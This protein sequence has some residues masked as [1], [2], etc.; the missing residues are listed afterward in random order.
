MYDVVTFVISSPDE[1]LVNY[2]LTLSLP[3][4]QMYFDFLFP[5]NVIFA[6]FETDNLSIDITKTNTSTD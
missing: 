1:F 2:S 5:A 4:V 6:N 3:S